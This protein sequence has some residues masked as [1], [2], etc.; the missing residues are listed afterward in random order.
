MERQEAGILQQEG[1]SQ[2]VIDV[3]AMDLR[4]IGRIPVTFEID[5]SAQGRL[6]HG[7]RSVG[8]L[9]DSTAFHESP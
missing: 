4:C 5:T 3:A 7:L 6:Q 9:L 8:F 2:V 1:S